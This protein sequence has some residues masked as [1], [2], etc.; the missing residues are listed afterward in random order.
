[1]Y[2]FTG[3]IVTFFLIFLANFNFARFNFR[4]FFLF[5]DRLCL[6]K[7]L[8]QKKV[9]SVDKWRK[10]TY[11]Q[12]VT[13][14]KMTLLSFFGTFRHFFGNFSYFLAI[15]GSFWPI[16]GFFPYFLALLGTFQTY[17]KFSTFF[18]LQIFNFQLF[19]SPFCLFFRAFFL[20]P[21]ESWHFE[22]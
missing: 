18:F 15:L 17:F 22:L 20:V 9:K 21:I 19:F 2:R 8:A 10:Q 13:W 5:L 7:T 12:G 3:T 4:I 14:R 11:L 16:L 6:T 1:M